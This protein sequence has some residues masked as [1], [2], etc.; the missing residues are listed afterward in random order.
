MPQPSESST[1]DLSYYTLASSHRVEITVGDDVWPEYT[2]D[3]AETLVV[4]SFHSLHI[5]RHHSPALGPIQQ[6]RLHVAVV[7]MDLGVKT[8]L[9]GLPDGMKPGKCSLRLC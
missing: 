3:L 9:T 4:K 7:Q 6:Y 8:V 2:A 5:R 1:L